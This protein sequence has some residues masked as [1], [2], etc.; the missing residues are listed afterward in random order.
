MHFELNQTPDIGSNILWE[1][2]KAFIRG[3]ILSHISFSRNLNASKLASLADKLQNLDTIYASSPS[4]SLY[5]KRVQLLAEHDL[6]MRSVT[7]R[8]LLQSR[9]HF[10]EHGDKAGKLLAHQA[11]A[12]SASRWITCIRS[13]SGELI[14]DQVGINNAFANFYADLYSRPGRLYYRLLFPPS[15]KKDKD[16]MLCGSYQPISLLNVDFKI[17]SNLQPPSA[18]GFTVSYFTRPNRFLSRETFFF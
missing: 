2:F 9:H 1:A 17:V 8:Q 13:L 4:P 10:F 5:T 7:A 6:I 12:S 11:C 16:P 3:Q 14:S 18:K 15:L